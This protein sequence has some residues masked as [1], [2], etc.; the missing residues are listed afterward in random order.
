MRIIL[1]M[2]VCVIVTVGFD[3][4]LHGL[5]HS[6]HGPLDAFWRSEPR[7]RDTPTIGPD[8]IFWHVAADVL[9]GLLLVVIL[10][11]IPN[12][13]FIRG[14]LVG[15]IVGVLMAAVWLHVYAAFEIG[16][17]I[18]LVLGGLQIIQLSLAATSAS[19]VLV[20]R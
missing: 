17:R 10:I 18:S 16:L 9:F 4:V 3:A 6:G 15:S 13:T 7:Q 20:N 11:H 14:V 5:S 2:A 8:S 19:L 12:L 1:A